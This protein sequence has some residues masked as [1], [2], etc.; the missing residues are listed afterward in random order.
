MTLAP[1]A[2]EGVEAS[3][4]GG[5]EARHHPLVFDGANGSHGPQEYTLPEN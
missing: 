1:A 3:E 4:R 2:C 5:A